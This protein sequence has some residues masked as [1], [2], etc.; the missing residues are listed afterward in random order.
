MGYS[1]RMRKVEE[2]EAVEMK[3]LRAAR[4]HNTKLLKEFHRVKHHTAWLRAKLQRLGYEFKKER[5]QS[6]NR[7]HHKKVLDAILAKLEKRSKRVA[8]RMLL[9]KRKIAYYLHEYAREKLQN[10]QNSRKLSQERAEL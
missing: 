9:L 2:S 3:Q 4:S 10:K 5:A 7:I 1:A 6:L 8:R